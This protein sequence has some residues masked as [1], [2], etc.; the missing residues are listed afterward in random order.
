MESISFTLQDGLA[1]IQL[2]RPDRLNAVSLTML[3][4]LQ[5][6]F[7]RLGKEQ[8]VTGV[9]LAGSGGN[10]SAGADLNEI[11]HF[12]PLE[13]IAFAEQGQKLCSMIEG[14]PR[15]VLVAV[16]G[17]ALGA[18]LELALSCDYILA[19]TT[20]QFAFRELSYGVLPAFGG[21]QRLPRLVGKAKAKEMIFTGQ[22]LG[23]EEALRIGL[24]NQ[25][26]APEE[27]LVKVKGQLQQI[28]SYGLLSLQLGKEV[29]DTGYEIN[30]A[31]ACK[32]E[33]DAYAVCFSTD[34]QKEGMDAFIEKRQPRFTGK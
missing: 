24:I 28:C 1:H 6:L 8:A 27:M 31:A 12:T 29:I 22:L 11:R 23:A 30:L 25:L 21:T 5:E 16:S 4:E 13:A 33:R 15:P 2:Q 26:F 14:F 18:G 17:Y 20:A 9:L 19:D 34:D 32:M 3:S 10:F 7:E